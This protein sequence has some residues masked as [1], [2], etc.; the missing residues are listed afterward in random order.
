MFLQELFEASEKSIEEVFLFGYCSSFA[1]ALQQEIGGDFYAMVRNG[2]PLHVYVKKD[3]KN[4]DVRGERSTG[5]MALSLVGSIDSTGWKI[6]GPYTANNLPCKKV[7]DKKLELAKIFIA[8]HKNR[9][10]D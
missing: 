4:Y 7:T 10:K 1:V 6:E 9:F 3:G 5:Q 8:S 2:V